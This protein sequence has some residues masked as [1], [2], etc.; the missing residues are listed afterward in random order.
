MQAPSKTVQAYAVGNALVPLLQ[1]ECVSPYDVR[2]EVRGMTLLPRHC[3]V[4]E[5]QGQQRSVYAP[6]QNDVEV[7][8]RPI[9]LCGFTY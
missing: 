7:L 1:M 3:C 5:L 8:V 9:W 6:I 2:V 4:V